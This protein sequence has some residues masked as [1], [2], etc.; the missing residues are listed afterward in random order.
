MVVTLALTIATTLEEFDAAAQ[1]PGARASGKR[2]VLTASQ[3]AIR[4]ERDV[5]STAFI[6]ADGERGRVELDFSF[7]LEATVNFRNTRGRLGGVP[8]I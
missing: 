5:P 4:R 3:R 8:E 1:N 6:R 7:V 2:G